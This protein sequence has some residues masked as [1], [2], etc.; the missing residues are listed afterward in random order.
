[1]KK[2]LFL[3]S[4]I[5]LVFVPISVERLSFV[6]SYTFASNEEFGDVVEEQIG[7]LDT[8]EIDKVIEDLDERTK[9]LFEEES[10]LDK[11]MKIISGDFGKN[12]GSILKYVLSFALENVLSFVPIMAT[13]IAVAIFGSILQGVKANKNSSSIRQVINFVVYGIV[14]ILIFSVFSKMINSVLVTISSMKG[15]MDGI[16]PILLTLLTSIGGT[17]SVGV[18][19]PAMAILSTVVIN[20]FQLFLMPLFLFTCILS[21]LNNMSTS[22]KLDKLIGFLNSLF[23]WTIGIIFTIFI[24]FASFQGLT[25]GTIDGFSIKTAK[26]TLKNYIPIVGGYMSDGVFV[27]LAGCNLIKNA[28]GLAGLLLLASSI[29]APIL[30]IIIFSLVLKLSAGLIEPL[31]NSQLASLV[32]S[33]AKN[34]QML[35]AM[36]ATISFMYILLTGLVMGSANII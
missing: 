29:I 20:I 35:V 31:G 25:A 28:V 23:K 32:A 7:N 24:G 16:F 19:Q 30:E 26:Y 10:F 27:I 1:M 11:L 3:L 8:S 14:V 22:V 33:L 5:C 34:L 6:P 21:L 4:I 9:E 15:Q 17:V 2:L 13:I 18:Y 36:L 12:N